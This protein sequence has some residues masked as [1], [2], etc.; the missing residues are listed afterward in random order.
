[1]Q[2]VGSVLVRNEDVFVEQAIRN[3]ASFCDRIH[4][5][6]HR[7]SD[8]TWEIL[9]ALARE[10]DHLELERSGDATRSHLRLEQYAGTP[11]WV[12]GVDGDELYDP[13]GL[14]RLRER[15]LVG[16]YSDWF[17]LKAHVLHCEALDRTVGVARGYLAPPSRAV[18]KL[19]NFDAIESWPGGWERLH[20]PTPTF[21]RGY[22]W[23]SWR[24]LVDETTWE[25]DPLRALHLCFLRRSSRDCDDV[26]LGR[27]NLAETG[28]YR[29][30]V[31]G[32]LRRAVRQP[33]ASEQMKVIEARGATWKRDKYRRG[34][35]VT[36][37][38]RPFFGGPLQP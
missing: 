17:R 29:R 8:R 25:T 5:L 10:L 7:S 36:V 27:R 26:A 6:D 11:T 3:V 37:D 2:I 18:T 1:M 30:G 9:R 28:L 22:D 38:A 12:L 24:T 16:E 21:R 34:D 19:F 31:L 33:L 14:A 15:L 35:P 20:G 4:A 32:A 23:D 13:T